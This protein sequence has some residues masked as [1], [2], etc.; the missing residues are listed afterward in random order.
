[1]AFGDV[2]W[3]SG[4][5][6][7]IQILMAPAWVLEVDGKAVLLCGAAPAADMIECWLSLNPQIKDLPRRVGLWRELLMCVAMYEPN[8]DLVVRI[9]DDNKV[10]RHMAMLAG[11][12][13]T[14]EM[15]SDHHRTWLRLAFNKQHAELAPSLSQNQDKSRSD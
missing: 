9:R 3:R 5:A 13:P 6:V 10:G 7:A 4:R 12:E 2:P 15:V 1:V 11:F 14:T 8:K